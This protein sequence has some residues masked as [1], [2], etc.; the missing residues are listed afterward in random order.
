[1][2]PESILQTVMAAAGGPALGSFLNGWHNRCMKARDANAAALTKLYGLV[3]GI[4]ASDADQI[5]E[6]NQVLALARG[7]AMSEE[8]AVRAFRSLEK[9]T[10]WQVQS[11]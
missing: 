9:G 4:V 3:V 7:G 2:D 6:T 10:F 5:A 8:Q 11:R 1:M